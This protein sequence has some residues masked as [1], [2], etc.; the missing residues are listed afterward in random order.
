MRGFVK[1]IIFFDSF[2]IAVFLLFALGLG[3]QAYLALHG[4]VF[5]LT[6]IFFA[7]I[8]VYTVFI[9]ICKAKESARCAESKP[10]IVWNL[11]LS[12]VSSAV[13]L[14]TCHL[15]MRDLRIY[16]DGIGDMIGFAVGLV[17]GGAIWLYTLACWAEALDTAYPASFNYKGFI[18]ELIAAGIFY[19][20]VF[21]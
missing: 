20:L 12:T 9:L 21:F 10:R 7:A 11:F 2:M 16:G 19:A 5:I 6:T 4:I 13:S 3:Y 18:K 8:T 15:F 1:M 14:Y 17:V